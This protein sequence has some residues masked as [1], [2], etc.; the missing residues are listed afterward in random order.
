MKV[1]IKRGLC[2]LKPLVSLDV[3]DTA[4]FRKVFSPIDLFNVVEEKVG[5]NF[6]AL[7]LKAQDKARKK[8]IFYNIIDIYKEMDFPFSPKEE[9]K[10][11]YEN[12]KANP[13]ILEL[14]NKQEA[15]Y[16][17]ISD[18]Y[19]PASVIA[20]MLEKCGYKN[21]QVFVSCELKAVKGDG[22]LFRKV[23]EI[24]GRK[25]SKHIGDN[26][27][28]DILGAQ[29]DR[30]KEVEFIGPP[31][32]NKEVVTPVLEN[33][34][35]RKL[36]IDEELSKNSIEEKIGYQFAPLI[37]AFTQFVLDSASDSQTIFFNGRDGFLMYIVAR[38]IL[39]TKKKVKY[40]RF[41]RKSCLLIDISTHLPLTHPSNSPSLHFFKIQ[42]AKSLRDFLKLYNLNEN[43]DY[44][45]IFKEY[46][47][48]MD[49][50]IEFHGRRP[51]ILEDVLIKNQEEF[52]SR[53]NIEKQNFLKYIRKIGMRNNDIF[54]DLGYAGTIQGIIKRNTGINL[55]GKYI[56]TYDTVG[57]YMGHTFDKTSFL[58][59]GLLR[60]YGGALIEVVF[61]EAK[62]TVMRYDSNGSPILLNDF[63]F[64]KE[65]SRK[66]FRG[67]FR[68]VKDLIRENIKASAR[69]CTTVLKRYLDFPTISE[70]TFGNTDL[71]ENGTNGME[72]ITWYNKN[73]IRQ[74]R[75]RECFNRSYW[76]AAFKLLLS[77]DPE[78]KFLMRNL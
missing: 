33:V 41:S 46:S 4:I 76:K 9:I 45:A 42:R 77:N 13:E 8:S 6:K 55:K 27:I 54:V 65:V 1:D 75:L 44:S 60:S 70:A 78:Y 14:Y 64:R 7:R 2:K 67:V 61:T 31:I 43:R 50:N 24:L 22:N 68:G 62:G 12:C 3:F 20:S 74:G 38:W 72:S 28:C 19:L 21:P 59:V 17:F 36:L 71:F 57:K 23:E 25:I 10:A 26:Y 39:K 29:K 48:N 47:I 66:I 52:Y 30:I 18:M 34:K 15:D 35:L 16:V 63:K 69:D 32:Y 58:P 37:L 49:T 73:Y 5:H 11:E 56:N 53:I 40:C 51:M